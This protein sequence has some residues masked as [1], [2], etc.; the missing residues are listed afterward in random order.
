MTTAAQN[1][2]TVAAQ[3]EAKEFNY[4]DYFKF[5]TLK[6]Y[7]TAKLK[8]KKTDVLDVEIKRPDINANTY[9][10]KCGAVKKLEYKT[11]VDETGKVVNIV[12]ITGLDVNK[13]AT[14]KAGKEYNVFNSI[15][16][17]RAFGSAEKA[18]A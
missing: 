16:K 17:A 6:A 15:I 5:Q 9:F 11:T 18:L 3:T 14:S 7:Y 8:G 1:N 12:R 13:K 10:F 4:F 2:G